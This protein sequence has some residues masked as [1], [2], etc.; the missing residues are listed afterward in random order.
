MGDGFNRAPLV[1]NYAPRTY[2]ICL[3]LCSHTEITGNRQ[4]IQYQRRHNSINNYAQK[5]ASY[6]IVLLRFIYT[7]LS[8][9]RF[10]REPLDALLNAPSIIIHFFPIRY[11]HLSA[12]DRQHL[13]RLWDNAVARWTHPLLSHHPKCQE[14]STPIAR[15]RPLA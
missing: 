2:L 3:R 1:H 12:S 7:R 11:L 6:Y 5:G 9:L 8:Q 4:E 10:L 14:C 13:A 15:Y